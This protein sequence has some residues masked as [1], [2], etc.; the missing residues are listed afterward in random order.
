MYYS[1]HACCKPKCHFLKVCSNYFPVQ[2][3]LDEIQDYTSYTYR[4]YDLTE[5]EP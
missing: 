2:S 1:V 4:R 3:S 5:K